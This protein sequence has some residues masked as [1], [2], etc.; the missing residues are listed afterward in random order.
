MT[1][2]KLTVAAALAVGITT[3]SIASA[4]AACPCEQKPVV[5][6]PS[7]G[8]AQEKPVVTGQACPCE[9]TV[10]KC[11]A[12]ASALCPSTLGLDKSSMRQIYA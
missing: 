9:T 7:C 4:M 1:I 5:T 10:P 11:D 3:C 12:P 6:A 8:C 2:K